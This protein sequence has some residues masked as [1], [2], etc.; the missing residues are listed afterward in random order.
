MVPYARVKSPSASDLVVRVRAMVGRLLMVERAL[1]G[2]GR[3]GDSMV[4]SFDG[5]DQDG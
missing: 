1:V 2:G 5:G 4:P 3:L